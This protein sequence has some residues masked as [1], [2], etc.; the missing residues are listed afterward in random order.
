[1][2]D[3][4]LNNVPPV[5]AY[6]MLIAWKRAAGTVEM[7]DFGDNCHTVGDILHVELWIKYTLSDGSRDLIRRSINCDVSV[8]PAE[9]LRILAMKLLAIHRTAASMS[10]S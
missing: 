4:T 1:M 7:R 8:D 6:D 5:A 3:L 2:G 9:P 10:K